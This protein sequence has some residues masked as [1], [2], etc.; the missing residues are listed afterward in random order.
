MKEAKEYMSDA[1][2]IQNHSKIKKLN[3]LFIKMWT[4]LGDFND[5]NE[6]D[7]SSHVQTPKNKYLTKILILCL[8]LSSTKSLLNCHWS[9]MFA[10]ILFLALNISTLFSPIKKFYRLLG[11]QT[12]ESSFVDFGQKLWALVVP[13]LTTGGS[14]P[15]QVTVKWP[16]LWN[17]L[18][19]CGHLQSPNLAIN[20]VSVIYSEI[21]QS[22]GTGQNG[23]LCPPIP[24]ALCA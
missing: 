3:F 19:L 7:D 2:G 22:Y 16:K 12:Y 11:I 6:P 10:K 17:F 9:N 1:W 8:N 15:L 14:F 24:R 21:H 13:T 5:F 18:N 23:L 4:F 20:C